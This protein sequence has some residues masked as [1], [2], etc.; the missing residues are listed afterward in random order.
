MTP[1]T[2]RHAL[3]LTAGA[4]AALAS[5]VGAQDLPAH[6]RELHAAARAEGQVTWYTGQ[7]QAEPSEAA[8][9][10]FNNRYPGVRVNVVRSTSQVAFQRLSQDMRASVAQCDVFSSTDW[11]HAAF[12]KREGRLQPFKPTN[13]AGLLDVVRDPDPDNAF[14]ITYLGLYMVARQS[15]KVPES[16]MPATWKDLLDPKWRNQLA[17]GHPGFSGAIGLWCIAMQ[18]AYGWDFFK[19]L[20]RN[21][22]QIGRSSA[23]PVTTINA[24]ER[25]IGVAVPSATALVSASRGNP[26][27]LVYPT[28]GTLLVPS[29]S[30]IIKTAPHPAAA[31]LF[32]EFL[33]SS[34]YSQATRPF[35]ETS[36]RADVPPPDGMRPLAQIKTI[37]APPAETEK[38]MVEVK[39]LWRDTF[40]V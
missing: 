15:Q 7:M 6:E 19:D 38:G 17:V 18:K 20:E 9:T 36:L 16:A 34:T 26:I 24:G 33:A 25:T 23:D 32:M 5:P 27:A 8:A 22:P 11:S 14:Q 10:A 39:E 30:G 12:L 2:R 1:I 21:K 35:F 13:S 40:G 29:P 28:D 3:A 31:K 37:Q 4:T